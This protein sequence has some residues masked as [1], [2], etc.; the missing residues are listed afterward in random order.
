MMTSS[1]AFQFAGVA[2]LYPAVSCI[3]F[4]VGTDDENRAHGGIVG[5]GAWIPRNNGT[6]DRAAKMDALTHDRA[7]RVFPLLVV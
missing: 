6:E 5:C 2:T 1:P 4:F 7:L 3:D